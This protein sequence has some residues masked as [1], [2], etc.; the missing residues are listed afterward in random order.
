MSDS[1][2]TNTPVVDTPTGPTVTS[3]TRQAAA[4]RSVVA[5]VAPGGLLGAIQ[6]HMDAAGWLG[7]SHPGGSRWLDSD[8][9][10]TVRLDTPPGDGEA[11][12]IVE[13]WNGRDFVLLRVGV[14]APV[15]LVLHT[16]TAWHVIG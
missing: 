14:D 7:E 15:D 6:R 1:V 8:N 13:G 16:L 4:G 10:R 5:P 2:P 11:Y 9:R 3:V 12:R